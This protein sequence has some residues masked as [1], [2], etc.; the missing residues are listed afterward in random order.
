MSYLETDNEI[1]FYSHKKYKYSCFSNFYESY[2]IEDNIKYCNSEQYFMYNKCLLFD[3]NNNELLNN[4]LNE[5][6]PTK[7]KKYGRQVKNYNDEIW[8]EKRYDIM[9]NA[10]ILKFSQTLTLQK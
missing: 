4:I 10:L 9:K 3:K 7:I 1:Y 8:N 2:F 5:T 6:S